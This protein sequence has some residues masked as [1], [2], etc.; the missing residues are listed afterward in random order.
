ML[1]ARNHW[2][3]CNQKT[4]YLCCRNARN[5]SF[6]PKSW[7]TSFLSQH[8]H[9]CT[10]RTK[11]WSHFKW[12]GQVASC[13]TLLTAI[14]RSDQAQ[15][16]LQ[17]LQWRPKLWLPIMLEA[18][19]QFQGF[20]VHSYG[21]WPSL[22]AN[23]SSHKLWICICELKLNLCMIISFK[24]GCRTKWDIWSGQDRLPWTS[25]DQFRFEITCYVQVELVL[26]IIVHHTWFIT[27]NPFLGKMSSCNVHCAV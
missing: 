1:K 21:I 12:R 5:I 26:C 14:D 22:L 18:E 27:P 6:A 16:S 24:V 17:S 15:P 19:H 9:M 20:W 4:L 13:A 25:A 11:C 8:R 23:K 3:H 10:V 2:N 7:V